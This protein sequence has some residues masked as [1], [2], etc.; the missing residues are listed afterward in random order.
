M[1]TYKRRDMS[2][3]SRR[4][5]ARVKAGNENALSLIDF[6]AMMTDVEMPEAEPEEDVEM[7]GGE[8]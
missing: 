8:I 6:L 2:P 1:A 4:D 5:L 7:D 3:E